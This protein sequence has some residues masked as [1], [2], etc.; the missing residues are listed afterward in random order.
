MKKI[1]FLAILLL[2]VSP[3]LR[4]QEEEDWSFPVGGLQSSREGTDVSSREDCG[5]ITLKLGTTYF[6]IFLPSLM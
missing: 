6:T 3:F 2:G 5:S 1:V 4:A